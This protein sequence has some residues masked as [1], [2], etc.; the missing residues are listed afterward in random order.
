MTAGFDLPE[1]NLHLVSESE[2]FGEM[3]LGPRRRQRRQE[4]GEPVRF[5][6][7]RVGDIVVHEEHGLGTY[8]GLNSLEVN[9]VRREFLILTYLGDEKLYVP[10]DRLATVTKYKGLT[11]KQPKLDHLGGKAWVTVKRKVKEAVWKVAQDLLKLYARRQLIEG[12]AF[13]MADQLFEELEESF[14]FDETPGQIKAINDVI[15]DLTSTT[16]MDRLVC[17]DVGYGKTEVAIRAAFKVVEDKYQVAVLVPTTVLAEQHV[18][19]FRER[20]AGFPVTIHCLNRFRSNAEQ[21]ETIKGL[22]N[23][24]VDIVIGTH[25]LL[26]KDVDFKR[27]GLLIV[28]EEHRFGVAHK[29]KLKRLRVGVDV[30]TLTAT[31]IPRTLQM[32]LLGVRD[33]SIISTAP[34]HR[35]SVKTFVAKYDDL[36]IKEAVTREMQRQGQVFLVSSRVRTIHEMARKVQAL[37]PLARVAVAHGQMDGKE[38]EEIMVAFVHREIDVLVCTTIIESGLDIPNANTIIITR[39]DRLGLAEI[40]QLRGRVGRSREQAFAYLLVPSLDGLSKDAQQRLQALMD[41]NELGGGFKLA[42]SDLQ[43][44]GGGNILGESQSGTIA[45]VGYDLYLD[46]LQKTVEDLKRG[47]MA[48]VDLEEP[49]EVEPEINLQL[50]AFLPAPYIV[51]ANQ[52]YIAYRR[53]SFIASEEELADLTDELVDRYGPL[54]DEA[55]NLL[56]VVALKQDLKQAR[57][58]RLEQGIGTLAFSFHDRTPVRPE[59]VLQMVQASRGAIR[60]LPDSR[61][62][63]KLPENVDVSVIAM[64]RKILRTLL[65][66]AM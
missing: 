43:I 49:V 5:E 63:V 30:L 62:L 39:A 26:S 27:L 58:S 9:G 6:E 45:A 33:L 55:S 22:A 14:P 31:P 53:L 52:R 29:E 42:M 60:L 28:D 34:E 11:D 8:Q 3:R 47:Q 56:A 61:L 35:R 2:L 51:D 20:L 50:S 19:T 40:Y 4:K 59:K 66:D 46:L 7:L 65:D 36:V 57:I 10:V 25:R 32:S 12:R 37:V 48:G 23:G 44:R 18:E 17:G 16:C 54:P 38:L 41:Y 64:A 24:R 21:R 15:G 1:F 13:S